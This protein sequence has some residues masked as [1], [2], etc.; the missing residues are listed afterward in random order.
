MS[1]IQQAWKVL[2]CVTL[3]FAYL[4]SMV[5]AVVQDTT[6]DVLQELRWK[7]VRPGG[8]GPAISRA[9]WRQRNMPESR[10]PKIYDASACLLKQMAA[11]NSGDSIDRKLPKQS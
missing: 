11:S 4:I 6:Q 3:A 8:Q 2:S 1:S 9:G 7:S 10:S 5:V